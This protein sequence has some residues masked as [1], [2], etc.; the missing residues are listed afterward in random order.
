MLII[1]KILNFNKKLKILNRGLEED[2][3]TSFFHRCR[4]LDEQ[5]Q[6]HK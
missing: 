1:K 3:S 5:E 6:A 4:G 2:V